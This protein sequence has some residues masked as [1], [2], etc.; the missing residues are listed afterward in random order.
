M[1]KRGL[2]TLV[3]FCLALSLLLYACG[4]GSGNEDA[5]TTRNAHEPGWQV[6]HSVAARIAQAGNDFSDC[7]V[8]HRTDFKGGGGVPGCFECHTEGEPFSNFHPKQPGFEQLTWANPLN[9]GRAAKQNLF[10]CQGC[11]GERGGPGSN[12]RFNVTLRSLVGGCESVACHGDKTNIYTDLVSTPPVRL[13]DTDAHPINAAHPGSSAPDNFWWFGQRLEF[14]GGIQANLGH[15]DVQNMQACTLCHGLQG[16]GGNGPSCQE[17]HVSSPFANPTGCISCHGRPVGSTDSYIARTGGQPLDPGFRALVAQG[18]HLQH[19]TIPPQQ[20]Q[21]LADCDVC[22][23]SPLE[24]N[25]PSPDDPNFQDFV[26][27]PNR[28]VNKHHNFIGTTI[29]VGTVAP[30]APNQP[31]EIYECNSCHSIEFIIV[32]G[33]FVPNFVVIRDCFSCHT[34]F[35]AAPPGVGP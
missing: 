28:N 4:G 16:L 18:Y 15:W 30:F 9:H 17:C 7:Q 22:H 34:D 21:T 12:P 19:D 5:P 6:D 29:P 32:N 33:A 26:Q 1:D 24:D 23:R 20:R 2:T 10:S 8:C 3:V 31:G 14:E 25:P 35:L 27:D 11:H 13:T